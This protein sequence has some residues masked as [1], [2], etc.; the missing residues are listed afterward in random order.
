MPAGVY[1]FLEALGETLFPLFLPSS[2]GHWH[3]LAW[4][5]LLPLQRQ[6]C[7]LSDYSSVV[8]S[9]SANRQKKFSNFKDTCDQTGPTRINCKPLDISPSINFQVNVTLRSRLLKTALVWMGRVTVRDGLNN[10]SYRNHLKIM[11]ADITYS[12]DGTS[13]F[14]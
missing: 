8:I 3:S 12:G 9:P 7:C 11:I 2:R 1:S 4:G 5:P 14:N 6:L 10:R 13:E